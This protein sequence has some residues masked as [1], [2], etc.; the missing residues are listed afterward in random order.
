MILLRD[1]LCDIEGN[2]DTPISMTPAI[3]VV[4][5]D[6]QTTVPED[7]LRSLQSAVQD[8]RESAAKIELFS[9]AMDLRHRRNFRILQDFRSALAASDQ[10]SLVFQPRID[11][12]TGEIFSA[13][14]LLRWDHP[15]LGPISPVE[16]IPV[17]E[18][19]AFAR[20][21]TDWVMDEAISHI[22]SW[23]QKGLRF[24]L[25]LNLSALNLEE[26]DFFER[27]M[28][29][30][31]RFD[32]EPNQI[33]L[34]LTETVMM[35][36]TEG[37]FGLLNQLKTAG[38][39]L[40][41]DDFGTGYS[42]LAY[43]QKLPAD[44]VKIDRSFVADMENGNRERVLVRSMID[45]SHSLGYRVVAEGVETQEAADLLEVMGCDEIQGY[46][47]SRPVRS[48]ALF[49]WLVERARPVALLAG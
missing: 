9:P 4:S 15:V 11:V 38:V 17:V 46:W 34:E 43:L 25:S 44:V 26:G 6:P 33:E 18:A 39:Q 28:S 13:E 36:E 48:D 14:A 20:E 35:K 2:S 23:G 37:A 45:L 5:Y 40:A 21:L 29:K 7:I 1:L 42:S 10:L 41:I 30:L 32:V 49:D 22:S 27:L 31:A 3:G 16:F 24:K 12:S 47:L 19:S 8:A